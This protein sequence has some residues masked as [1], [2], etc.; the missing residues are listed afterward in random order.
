MSGRV[1]IQAGRARRCGW[2][3]LGAFSALLLAGVGLTACASGGSGNG[4][5]TV[6]AVFSDV[7]SLTTGASV[8]LADVN[9]G[10]VTG[11][12]LD[13]DRALVT[14]AVRRSAEVP[15]NVTAELEQTTILGQYVVDLVPEGRPVG[16][17]ANHQ[18][19]ART[20]VVPGLQELVQSGTEVF[21]AISAAELSSLID[22]SAV[23]FGGQGSTIRSLL[24]DFGTVLAG[25]QTQTTQIR[26]LI[27]RLDAFSAGLAPNAQQDAAAVS[28]LAQATSVLAQQSNQFVSL[29]RSL[30]TL[31]TQTRAILDTGLPDIEDQV[32]ALE[33][34]ASQLAAHQAALAQLL[35]EVPTANTNLASATYQHEVQ[36][37][38]NIIVCGVPGL[39][40]GNAP[41]NTCTPN[42]GGS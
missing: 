33:A 17:L 12:H 7:H 9:V 21:G 25:Y 35:Q 14:M 1:G 22:N 20:E 29:L 16:L 11:I 4:S 15:A 28:Q 30:D 34:T 42:G 27:D 32:A 19:I 10:Q 39:G 36:I 38:Q 41:T 37:L 23:A 24:D 3:V 26:Q 8:Q 18:R 2:R 31:A 5:L 6:S 13:G 40:E